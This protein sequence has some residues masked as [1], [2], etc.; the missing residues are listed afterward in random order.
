MKNL[1]LLA[2]LLMFVLATGNVFASQNETSDIMT[3]ITKAI[4]PLGTAIKE[5]QNVVIAATA[6]AIFA[7]IIMKLPK[8]Q[9][10]QEEIEAH[11]ESAPS[12]TAIFAKKEKEIACE[13]ACTIYATECADP[14][15]KKS[16]KCKNMAVILIEK[17]TKA[18]EQNRSGQCNATIKTIVQD[19]KNAII[20]GQRPA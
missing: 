10:T 7:I 6:F 20:D 15:S 4:T 19:A 16:D 14:E 8:Q 5:N 3:L 2:P 12:E 17:C 11:E 9:Y 1:R 13:D 18:D